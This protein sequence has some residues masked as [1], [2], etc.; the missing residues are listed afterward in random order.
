MSADL[1]SPHAVEETKPRP[2]DSDIDIETISTVVTRI[3]SKDSVESDAELRR[4]RSKEGPMPEKKPA[5]KDLAAR[6]RASVADGMAYYRDPVAVKNELLAGFTVA[7]LK[8]PESVAFSLVAHVHPLQGLYGSFFLGVI[9]DLFGRPGMV[10]GCAGALAAVIRVFMTDDGPFGHLC[11]DQRREYVFF[12][13]FLTGAL[14]MACGM[15]KISRVVKI[16]PQPAFIG[17][18]NGL[19]I[20]IGMSQMDTFKKEGAAAS[21]HSAYDH[22]V[23]DHTCAPVDFG[24][25]HDKEW[26]A[27]SDAETWLMCFHILF[28]ACVTEYLPKLKW[29]FKIGRVSICPATL[30]PSALV[31][32]LLSMLIEWKVFRTAFVGTTLVGDI[33]PIAGAAPPFHVPDVPWG[34]WATYSTCL[35]MAFSLCMIGLVESILTCRAVDELVDERS[36]TATKNEVC[37]A[38]GLGNAVSSFFMSMGGCAMI[39]QSM[40]NVN[41]GA[42]GKLSS[43]MAGLSVLIFV[44]AASGFIEIIPL[45]ALTGILVVVVLK[46]F[47]WDSLRMILKREMP[48]VDSICVILVTVLAV[49]TNLAIGVAAGVVWQ[50]VAKAWT[51]SSDLQV[52]ETAGR[53]V[54]TGRVYFANC[55]AFFDEAAAFVHEAPESGAVLDLSGA[56]LQDFSATSAVD[57]LVAR[58]QSAGKVLK[59]LHSPAMEEGSSPGASVRLQKQILGD[60]TE[61]LSV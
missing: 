22:A 56:V 28:V 37:V 50:A 44:I 5:P 52:R 40:I 18:F 29:S 51:D 15:M 54:V 7:I 23:E 30:L 10:S 2:V 55:E 42:R 25:S 3:P 46:T 21:H 61:K 38:Q 13:M 53:V 43:F 60:V 11:M 20:I 12:T 35:S 14:Q 58:Y 17:F 45:A 24:G 27:A 26:Y 59:V 16:I 34:E 36:S 39:G 1:G 48:V 31:G 47:K 33:S 41:T 9:S 4:L 57:A 8:V 19:A 32:T 49:T 6:V